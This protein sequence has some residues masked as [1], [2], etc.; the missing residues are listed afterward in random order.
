M[1]KDFTYIIPTPPPEVEEVFAAV[2]VTKEYYNEVQIRSE[3][4]LYCEW[5]RTTA[6]RHRQE[7]EKMRGEL[8][9]F[10]WFRRQ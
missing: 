1:S 2:E 8:N 9:L 4:K 5:Y 6:T 10:A 7:L 3:H